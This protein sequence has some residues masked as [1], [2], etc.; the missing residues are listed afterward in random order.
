[1]AATHVI[2]TNF[3][4]LTISSVSIGYEPN[5]DYFFG[6][7]RAITIGG[8]VMNI[9]ILNITATDSPPSTAAEDKKSYI[10]QIG[11]LSSALEHAVPEQLFTTDR[12]NPADAISAVKALSKANA[13]GQRIYHIT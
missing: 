4:L 8:A 13:Q 6:V 10:L 7:P 3:R 5:V 11:M 9:P 12:T 1:M 2:C